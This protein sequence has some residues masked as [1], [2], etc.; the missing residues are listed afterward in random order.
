M[1]VT[2]ACSA[3]A[4]Q[5]VYQFIS[6]VLVLVQVSGDGK[7]IKDFFAGRG[8]KGGRL[9]ITLGLACN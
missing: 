1:A 9:R 4:K 6:T 3:V 5:L 2:K 7:L 8:V